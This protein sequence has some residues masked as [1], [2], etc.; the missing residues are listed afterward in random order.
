MTPIK[1]D[2][3]LRQTAPK[4]DSNQI[5]DLTQLGMFHAAPRED[6]KIILNMRFDA[7]RG[8]LIPVS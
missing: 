3:F 4:V 8:A 6:E 7:E 2:D 1:L 5:L